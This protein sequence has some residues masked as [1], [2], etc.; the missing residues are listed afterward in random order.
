[1][2]TT[3]TLI[4][5][6]D[7]TYCPR[8]LLPSVHTGFFTTSADSGG[9]CGVS[10]EVRYP[11]PEPTVEM[12]SDGW[13]ALA[14]G[15][16]FIVMLNS[17]LEIGAGSD[18]FDFLVATLAAV[19][20]SVTP[21]CVVFLHRP[22]YAVGP[23]ATGGSR[24]TPVGDALE[25]TLLKYHVDLFLVGH[26]HNAFASAGGIYQSKTIVPPAPDAYAAPIHAC[27]GNAGMGLSGIN[28]THPPAWTEWQMN[29]YGYSDMTAYNETHAE[30]RFFDDAT[31]TL[32]HTIS[33][34]RAW[35]RVY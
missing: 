12:Q 31:D 10:T 17:E 32:Q 25:P 8:Y 14:H 18:Q 30:M 24:D 13:W 15:S 2:C 1:M 5:S 34:V 16:V 33:M 3:L 6:S 29:A 22:I 35:P 4:T 26:V 20:R 21:W 19:N 11:G 23:S 9:E 7:V 27:I 28:A